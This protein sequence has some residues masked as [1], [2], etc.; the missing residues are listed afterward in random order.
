M[1]IIAGFALSV[2]A[3]AC[4]Y[5]FIDMDALVAALASTNPIR[6]FAS[7]VLLLALVTLS[8]VRLKLLAAATNLNVRLRTATEATFAGDTLNLVLPA[9]MGDFARAT[10]L[11]TPDGSVIPAVN[12]S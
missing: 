7:L 11:R 12:L 3:L 8:A 9:N 6:L 10:M 4:L 1:R 2:F 5:A